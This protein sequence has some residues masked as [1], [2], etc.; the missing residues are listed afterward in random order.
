MNKIQLVRNA[1]ISSQARKEAYYKNKLQYAILNGN[2]YVKTG[3]LSAQ[4][5]ELEFTYNNKDASKFILGGRENTT[6]NGLD[7]GVPTASAM[8]CA[9]G[10]ATVLSQ[11]TGVQLLLVKNT[12]VLSNTIYTI[13][14]I[15]Q[16]ITRGTFSKF[17]ELY[18]GTCNNAGVADSRRFVGDFYN[19]KIRKSGVL[20]RS[21][22][23][24]IDNEDVVCFYDEVEKKLY[25][26]SGTEPFSAGPI[27]Q[28]ET[29]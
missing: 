27:I 14:G 7:V 18:L 15:N 5:L 25:Y 17:Y 28:E 10:G 13:N 2:Q 19:L 11:T 12:I 1:I 29:I 22:I 26:N 4:D 9:F 3:V 20:I 24:V 16:I 23:P 21:F 8:Y 6:L